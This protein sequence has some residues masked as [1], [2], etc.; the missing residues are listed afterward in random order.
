M[1]PF[2]FLLLPTWKH[3]KLLM[4]IQVLVSLNKQMLVRAEVLINLSKQLV[5]L[6]L[7]ALILVR[8]SAMIPLLINM[9][10]LNLWLLFLLPVSGLTKHVVVLLSMSLIKTSITQFLSELELCKSYSKNTL[11]T[12][13]SLRRV[14]VKN[15]EAKISITKLWIKIWLSKKYWTLALVISTNSKR[16]EKDTWFT[17]EWMNSSI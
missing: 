12:W 7:M 8:F 1:L 16:L 14:V 9:L 15:L 5:L 11:R 10:H 13:L 17:T 4:F 2:G 6:S 3:L